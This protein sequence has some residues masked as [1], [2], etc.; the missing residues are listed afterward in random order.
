MLRIFVLLSVLCSLLSFSEASAVNTQD[1]CTGDSIP[2]GW[3]TSNRSYDAMRCNT[4]YPPLAGQG[5]LS[6]ITQFNDIPVGGSLAV[7]LGSVPAGWTR[8]L[9]S[10]NAVSCKSPYPQ[11]WP[12]LDHNMMTILHTSCVNQSQASCYPVQPSV[13]L[14]ASPMTAQVPYAQFWG[15]T[16]ISFSSQGYPGLCIWVQNSG[17]TPSVWS[18]GGSSGT[19]TWP[20]VPVGGSS[21]FW[22]NTSQT[23]SAQVLGSAIT[24]TAASSPAPILSASPQTAIIPKGEFWGT[25][26]IDFDTSASGYPG[27]CIWIQNTG[28]NATLWGCNGTAIGS[29]IWPY[30]PIGGSTTFYLTPGGGS[31]TPALQTLVVHAN[32]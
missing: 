5:N 6:T 31:P 20:Y 30:V 17:S 1:I 15:S 12:S 32:R 29:G 22:L 25:T 16:D 10:F 7:C 4:P 28:G 2:S 14:S 19:L 23:S 18:C 13:T 8:S 21:T 11:S 3:I 9:T 26:Q 27:S 24:V